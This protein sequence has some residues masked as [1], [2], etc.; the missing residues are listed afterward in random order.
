MSVLRSG[1]GE[2]RWASIKRGRVKR[3][4]RALRYRIEPFDMANLQN[5][6]FARCDF[7]QLAG[8]LR[9]L[10]DGLLDQKVFARGK[11]RVRN[12]VVRVRRR[13]DRGRINHCGKFLQRSRRCDAVFARDGIRS[14]RIDIIDRAEVDRRQLGIEARVVRADVPDA[15]N[16]DSEVF[17]GE[18]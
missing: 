1:Y 12:R 2:S 5:Q 7:G 13:R 8:V 6:L 11:E 10:R 16:T 15:G 4:S 17:L 18:V 9:I 3:A 14:M